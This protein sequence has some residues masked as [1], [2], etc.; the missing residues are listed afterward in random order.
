MK[1]LYV[2][3]NSTSSSVQL[4][5]FIKAFYESDILKRHELRIAAFS[6]SAPTIGADY[7]MD[8]FLDFYETNLPL[9]ERIGFNRLK[10]EIKIYAPHLIINDLDHHAAIIANQL[11]I[12]YW[13]V[14]SKL[15]YRAI[16]DKVSKSL[17]INK[18]YFHYFRLNRTFHSFEKVRGPAKFNF[19][20]SYLCDSEFRPD[21]K[22]EYRWIRPY[23]VVSTVKCDPKVVCT[24][25]HN[26]KLFM[27]YAVTLGDA[28]LF[29][30]FSYEKFNGV[31]GDTI[32]HFPA[33]SQEYAD[34]ISNCYLVLSHGET[35]LVA[36]AF[37]NKKHCLVYSS[38][39]NMDT[40]LNGF[41]V[42][43]QGIGEIVLTRK[44]TNQINYLDPEPYRLNHDPN[45]YY[46]HEHL[47]KQC[48]R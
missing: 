12:P 8:S 7:T 3:D 27:S 24:V 41:F 42:Q 40:V 34:M 31:D 43:R 38:P 1:F 28:V 45:T 46:L 6:S 22:P 48:S 25:L 44:N 32:P 30:P 17:Q 36:D 10:D 15:L 5:R 11:N 26:D 29:S 13:N 20:Y 39:A 19:V 2:A 23:H 37:Y 16:T 21:L 33:E 35:S 9:N 47:E 18:K 4:S 14:S